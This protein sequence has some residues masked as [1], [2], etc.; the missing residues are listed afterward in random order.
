MDPA[1]VA[2][3]VSKRFRRYRHDRPRT[4]QEAV[5]RGLR[6]LGAEGEFWALREVSFQVKRGAMLGVIGQNGAGKTTL[7]RLVGGVLKPDAGRIAVSGRVGALIDLG[8]GFH[9]DLTGRENVYTN[10]IIA[11]LTR[12]EVDRQFRSI[13]EFAELAEF[14]DSPLRTYSTGMQLRLAFAVAT[15]VQPE[16]LLIDEIL[17]VGDLAYQGKCLERIRQYRTDGSA[18]LVVSHDTDLIRKL[19]DEALWLSGGR[20]AAAGPPDLVVQRYEQELR[21]AT[22]RQTPTH[23]ATQTTGFGTQLQLK[24]NRFGSQ[25]MRITEVS[26]FTR[27]GVAT[28]EIYG[29]DPL[30]VSIRYEAPHRIQSPIFSVTLSKEDGSICLDTNTAME[31]VAIPDLSGSGVARLTCERLDLVEGEYFVDVGVYRNDWAYAY[32]YHW[33]AY[34]LKIR[35]NPGGKGVLRPPLSWEIGV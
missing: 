16:V 2:D 5:L 13:V 7:L 3:Q 32:D 6:G 19:C 24:K 17:S 4:L 15:H 14:I 27:S 12:G 10:G 25:E 31:G 21:E 22:E 29:G 23:G 11:G 35:D 9:P 33:H 8:A 30:Q 20:V 28:T 18:I 34:P 26:L 1:I